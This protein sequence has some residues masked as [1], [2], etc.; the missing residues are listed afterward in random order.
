MNVISVTEK[1]LNACH[2]LNA[3]A[4]E[5][6]VIANKMRPLKQFT[7]CPKAEVLMSAIREEKHFGTVHMMAGLTHCLC[8]AGLT[9]SELMDYEYDETYKLANYNHDHK[10]LY[11]RIYRGEK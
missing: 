3:E 8:H 5:Q 9:P 10:T 7:P 1:V 2:R 4:Y 11:P 6:Q